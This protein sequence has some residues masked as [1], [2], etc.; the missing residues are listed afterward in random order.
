M[1]REIGY[2]MVCLRFYCKTRRSS[3]DML[4]RANGAA[5]KNIVIFPFMLSSSKHSQWF[6]SR[7]LCSLWSRKNTGLLLP[8]ESKQPN[9]HETAVVAAGYES[10]PK[11]VRQTVSIR[12]MSGTESGPLPEH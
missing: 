1:T 8:D 12:D 10:K 3:F 4:L 6:F 11:L 7:I 5:I 2:S 9:I